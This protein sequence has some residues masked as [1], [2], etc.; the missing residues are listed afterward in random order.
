[1]FKV[2]NKNPFDF[3]AHFDGVEFV[4]LSGK[5]MACQDAAVFHIFG[6]ADADKTP[7]LARHGWVRPTEPKEKGL[8]ILGNFIFTP[9]TPD[10]GVPMARVDAHRPP[11]PVVQ[12]GGAASAAP[13]SQGVL[14]R[15]AA[16]GRLP[17][18]RRAA[19]PA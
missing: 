9:L 17:G 12:G 4:F 16:V 3:H 14:E 6:L 2:E 18:S 8:E 5:E 11:A 19:E 1:M 13:P 10:Y 15:A 7:I